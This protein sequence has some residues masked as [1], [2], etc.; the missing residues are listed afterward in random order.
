MLPSITFCYLTSFHF[1]H[2]VFISTEAPY[3]SIVKHI[4]ILPYNLTIGSL[5]FNKSFLNT[6]SQIKSPLL[7]LIFFAFPMQVYNVT[8]LPFFDYV[9]THIY[10][11]LHMYVFINTYICIYGDKFVYFPTGMQLASTIIG[12]STFLINTSIVQFAYI[13]KSIS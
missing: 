1:L 11:V 3:Y 12:F 13:Q 7:L 8:E 4:I 9:Y 2:G 6:R 10:I 5:Y